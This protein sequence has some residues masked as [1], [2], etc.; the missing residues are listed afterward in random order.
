MEALVA[1]VLAPARPI[2]E[3]NDITATPSRVLLMSKRPRSTAGLP[4]P[5]STN[6]HGRQENL[7]TAAWPGRS[8]NDSGR[9]HA[10]Q[11]WGMRCSS[12]RKPDYA[13]RLHDSGINQDRRSGLRIGRVIVL[14]LNSLWCQ[15]A[16][17]EALCSVGPYSDIFNYKTALWYRRKFSEINF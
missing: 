13:P 11:T 3:N 14:H 16:P 10:A 7:R 2:Q 1:G 6:L 15:P 9:H 4:F 5:Y 12:W 8:R 17:R